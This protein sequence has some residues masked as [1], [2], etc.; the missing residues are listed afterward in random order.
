MK[1]KNNNK[2]DDEL[3]K[4]FI[5]NKSFNNDDNEI[6]FFKKKITNEKKITIVNELEELNKLI[7]SNKPQLF[8]LIDK[9]ISLQYKS[10]VLKKMNNI[11]ND[12]SCSSEKSK[13]ENWVYSFL[14]IPF[15][16][17]IDFPVS[18]KDNYKCKEYLKE[19]EKILNECI[20]GMDNVK[21]QFLQLIGKWI[22][23]SQSNGMVI[24]LKGPM[25]V[26]KTTI[27]K[28]GLSKI[29][30]R[31]FSFIA[32][33]GANDGSYLDG[34]SYTYEGS[35]YGKIVDII[36]QSNV[37]NP[38]IFFDELDK[39]SQ[40]DKG[41]EI[42]GIL[43]HITDITQNSH[44]QDKYFSEI[45][46]DL[47]KCLFVFSFNDEEL[48]NPILKDRMKVIDVKGYDK[49]EKIIITK[50]YII[51]EFLKEYLFTENDIIFSNEIL[52]YIIEKT[53][54]EEGV[55]NLKR[56]I[57]TIISKI[58][59]IRIKTELFE[60]FTVN[61]NNVDDFLNLNEEVI[62]NNMMYL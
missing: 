16:K 47:S 61:K 59:L 39:V 41:T 22:V 5:K 62:T 34:Y 57:E 4:K 32:L 31:P 55:R 6:N 54:K 40:T 36:I 2:K 44:F 17:F 23:N 18:F 15:H 37:L 7:Y 1:R 52:E 60:K 50:K 27:I 24:G 9:N 53:K 33:G 14:K 26:G 29:L 49:K 43:T 48:V 35:T 58:N 19:S 45:S 56:N 8:Q 30:N 12:E 51:P 28:N 42:I 25:G 21:S 10:I 13:L 11:K 46:I 20:Y 3:I 38:I